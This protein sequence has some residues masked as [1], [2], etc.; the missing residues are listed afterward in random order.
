MESEDKEPKARLSLSNLKK[1]TRIFRYLRPH[2]TIFSIGM[3]LLLF[4]SFISLIVPRLLGQVAGIG[5]EGSTSEDLMN[6][7]AMQ[8]NMSE[9][10]TVLIALLAIFV[11][12]GVVAFFRVYTFAIVTE[13]MMLALRNDTYRQMIRMP[14]QFFNEKRVG[15][16]TSR[17]SADITTIQETF[18]F[19]IAEF[20][21][22]VIIIVFGLAFLFYHS[23]SLTLYMLATIPVIVVAAVIFGRFIR[24]LGKETQDRISESNVIVQETLTGI[25]AVKSFANEAYEVLRYGKSSSVILAYGMK[26]AIWRGIFSSFI[27]IFLF[28][29][30]A[31]VLWQGA[32]LM[33]S[34]E[35]SAKLFVSFLLYTAMIG[36]S[37]GGLAAQYASIQRGV[38]AIEKVMDLLE[39]AAEPI[40]TDS[41]ANM[42][43]LKGDIEFSEVGFHYQSRPDVKVLRELSFPV[44][45]GQ[46]VALVGP[47]GA[48][49]STVVS[50]LLRFY[51]PAQGKILID[52]LDYTGYDLTALRSQMALVP[53]DVVLFGGTIRDNIAYGKPGCSDEEVVEAARQANALRFIEQFPDGMN[54]IVGERGIQLSGGQRQRIAIARAVLRNPRILI[55]DEA[56]SSLDS[57]SERLVQEALD[58]LMQGR[59]SIVIAHRLS[60]IRKSDRIFVLEKGEIREQGTH[61]ELLARQ[62]GLYRHL[63]ELQQSS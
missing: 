9:L 56:T 1:A 24:K 49:K 62:S 12:Q 31:F 15:D 10:S 22:Q 50:L 11:I 40:E 59:T 48:G 51:E 8:I 34:G 47:S 57:E 61:E 25:T 44:K 29:A 41:K 36:G 32:L 45:S 55:L 27:I 60:T 3:A 21:R 17:I 23:V 46:R 16:L 4:S 2:K 30:V 43:D 52:G 39:S 53:Q 5:I 6:L 20:I 35:L 18:T 14:M 7:G 33:Q 38:G 37:F 54:T 42:P 63:T 58:N 13:R 19:T 26:S 28:G